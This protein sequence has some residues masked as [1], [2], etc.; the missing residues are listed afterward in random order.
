[1]TLKAYAL[2][3]FD[4]QEE[5]IEMIQ[6]IKPVKQNDPVIVKLLVLTLIKLGMNSE[7]TLMLEY[8]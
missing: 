4:K 3:E 1:M 5:C 6:E 8:A 7:T 2:M